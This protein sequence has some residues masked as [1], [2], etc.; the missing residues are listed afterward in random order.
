M[1][2]YV[3][4]IIIENIIINAILLY[5][6]NYVLKKERRIKRI[7]IASFIGSIYVLVKY[8]FSI[9]SFFDVLMKL[10]ISI[11]MIKIGSNPQNMKEMWKQLQLFY[12]ITFIFGGIGFAVIYSVQN[13]LIRNLEIERITMTM[14][15][16]ILIVGI[17]ISIRWV[18][19]LKN[20]INKDEMYCEVEIKNENIIRKIKVMIDTGNLLKEPITGKP[21]IVIEKEQLRDLIPKEILDNVN[22]ILGGE[23]KE[24]PQKIVDKYFSKIRIIPFFSLGNKKGLLLGIK[25]KE[26]NII[27]N[28]E[29]IQHKD[30]FVGVYDEKIDLKGE[31]FG[32]VGMEL[33]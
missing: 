25:I 15:I 30:I 26:V 24:I 10:I 5:I 16:L 29:V 9:E 11:I 17:Y 14:I 4:V 20:K 27:K 7:I 31:Y 32:V 12:I 2:V 13:D 21:V 1:I 18:K 6:T 8:V 28:K 19:E 33:I 22:G 3:D 23:I